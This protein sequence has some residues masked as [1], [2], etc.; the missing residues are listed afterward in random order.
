MM[1]QAARAGGAGYKKTAVAEPP[2]KMMNSG[3][4]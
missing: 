4:R 1:R 2:R 3:R